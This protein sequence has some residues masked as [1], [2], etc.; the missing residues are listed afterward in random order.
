MTA[1]RDGLILYGT[2]NDFLVNESGDAWGGG[3]YGQLVAER[4]AAYL[5]LT[6]AGGLLGALAGWLLTAALA[7]RI[8]SLHS[9]WGRLAATFAGLALTVSAPAT[10]AITVNAVMLGQHLTYTG[11]VYTLHAA[12]RPASHLDGVPA[13]LTPDARSRQRLQPRSP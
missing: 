5:P 7:Y 11:P 12:L 3:I 6:V 8:R 9:G 4:S 2:V 13:W 10:W 1:K